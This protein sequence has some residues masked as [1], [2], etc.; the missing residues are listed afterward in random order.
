MANSFTIR[1]PPSEAPG[2]EAFFRSHGFD[3]TDTPHAFWTAKGPG[4]KAT[5]Y[6][7]GKLLLQGKEAD[8]WRGL[9][10]EISDHARPFQLGLSRHP[11][12]LP[13]VWAGTDESGKGDYF[14]PLVVSGVAV[15]RGD[16][17]LLFT[18]GVDDCKAIPDGKI[19][20]LEQAIKGL[21]HTETLFIG[22]EKYNSLYEKI[23]NLN[24]LLAWAHAKVIGNLLAVETSEPI[25]W[26]LIDRFAPENTMLKALGDTTQDVRLD[27]W[28]KAESDPAVAAASILARGAFLRGLSGLS[29]RFAVNLSPGAGAPVL[30]SGRRF[31]ESH[32]TAA[33]RQVA[34]VHFATT[35]QIGG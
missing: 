7:S 19:P 4:T 13:R 35:G 26:V 25:E 27:Q 21:C 17:E 33:L 23:G 29:K 8:V 24:R 28:P 30:T 15:K 20:E 18:L 14:G 34:K 1:L 5:F 9:L 6:R 10:G 11:K 2:T 31:I 22:P 12:P 16:M 32:G 3:F